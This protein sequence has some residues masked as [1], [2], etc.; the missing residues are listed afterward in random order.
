MK[1]IHGINDYRRILTRIEDDLRRLSVMPK[2]RYKLTDEAVAN[3]NLRA[4][5][6][7]S[8]GNFQA[9]ICLAEELMSGFMSAKLPLK[10]DYFFLTLVPYGFNTSSASGAEVSLEGLRGTVVSALENLSYIAAIDVGAYASV[11]FQSGRRGMLFSWHVHAIAWG[12]PEPYIER[13]VHGLNISTSPLF[14][15]FLPAHYRKVSYEGWMKRLLYAIRFPTSEYQAWR[16]AAANHNGT[17]SPAPLLWKQGSKPIRPGTAAQIAN[18]LAAVSL[19]QIVFG[20]REGGIIVDAAVETAQ[21]E[22][23]LAEKS[24]MDGL[25]GRR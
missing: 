12:A 24:R 10:G 11:R 2:R 20:G 13:L 17:Q 7:M 23:T 19:G 15:G 1:Y 5:P 22:M 9:R 18:Q 4:R 6:Y 21:A 25:Y 14:P 8:A 16:V 3:L